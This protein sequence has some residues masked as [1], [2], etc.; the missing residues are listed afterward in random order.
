MTNEIK[1]K[2]FKIGE[3]AELLNVEASTIRFWLT[4]GLAEFVGPVKRDK[5]NYRVLTQQNVEALRQICHFRFKEQYTVEGTITVMKLMI[6]TVR[7]RG[8]VKC[9]ICLDRS[10]T[11]HPY[12]G[13]RILCECSKEN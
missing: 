3:V 8:D 7:L 4:T 12:T 13:S 10:W 2:Y 1:K 6:D 9:T 11:Y 5:R